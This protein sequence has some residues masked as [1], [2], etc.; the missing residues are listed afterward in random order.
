M[1]AAA[2]GTAQGLA[3]P[4]GRDG[5]RCPPPPPPT[6]PARVLHPHITRCSAF[7]DGELARAKTI[8]IK[9]NTNR[10]SRLLRIT[11]WE[12]WAGESEAHS[13]T[14]ITAG[15]VRGRVLHG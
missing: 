1:L 6:P 13:L 2:R 15:D 14:S 7:L 10:T 12:R 4:A 9:L 8:A 11:W 3:R 5:G